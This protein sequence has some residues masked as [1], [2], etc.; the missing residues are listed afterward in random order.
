[1]LVNGRLLTER[2]FN[3]DLFPDEFKFLIYRAENEQTAQ[4]VIMDDT[5]WLTQKAMAELFD[6]E[7]HTIN[8]HLREIYSTQEL[9]ED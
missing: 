8:Y 5:V 4:V 7:S 1:M 2:G 9:Q 6:V 3:M